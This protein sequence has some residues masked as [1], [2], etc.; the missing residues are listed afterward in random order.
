[1]APARHSF[2]GV[3]PERCAGQRLDRVAAELLHDFSRSRL[4]AWIRSGALTVDGRRERP[5][6][7]VLGGEPLTLDAEVEAR[8]ADE[9]QPVPFAVV[10]EDEDLL[11]V[12][13]PA[14]VVVHP[15][16]GNPAGTLVNGLLAHRPAL[17]SLPRAGLV[18]RL[19]KDT[20]GLLVVAASE[21]ARGALVRA[22][23]DR[24]IERLYLAIV[25]GVLTAGRDVD[26]AIGRDPQRRTRQRAR[27]DG[28]PASTSVRVAQRY[29]GHTAVRATLG[30][31]R[32]HQVRVHMSAIGHP[33]VGDGRYG[34]RGRLPPH[35]SPALVEAVRG[36]RRQ[37]LHA[38]A[39]GF[40]HPGSG[41]AMRFS[42]PVPR[43]MAALLEVLEEDASRDP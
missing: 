1:M 39:L 28:R 14:G 43:D 19:D 17:A 35:P 38:R 16:A 24:E 22:M 11:V 27:P 34:A 21:A 31:G 8:G 20:S 6:Y 9:A 18:H 15:G 41:A 13:K 4:T 10:H 25:E 40:R 32:T 29:R 3:V 12:D 42:S 7:R 33:L 37:A 30:T 26:L 23:A 5:A 2:R 36:F